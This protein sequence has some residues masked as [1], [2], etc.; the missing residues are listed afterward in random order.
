[1]LLEITN[2]V[3]L[4]NE[5]VHAGEWIT[6]RD[7]C[8]WKA[9]LHGAERQDYGRHRYGRIARPPEGSPTPWA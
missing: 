9:P 2:R 3:A 7:F 8:Y 1:M 6:S 5:S 4:H